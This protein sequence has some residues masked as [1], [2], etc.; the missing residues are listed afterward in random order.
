MPDLFSIYEKQ[1]TKEVTELLPKEVIVQEYKS[2]K[3]RTGKLEDGTEVWVVVD[4]IG[5]VTQSKNPTDYWY[6]IKKRMANEGNELSTNCRVLKIQASNGKFYA[7]E[8]MTREQIFR[9]LQSIPSKKAEPFKL[10]LA[11]LANER[12]E[13]IENPDLAV[14]RGYDGYIKKGKSAKWA[15]ARVESILHRNTLTEKWLD[16]GV[17]EPKDF[18]R[19]TDRESKGTFGK[20]T[21]EMKKEKELTPTQ[22]L[23]DNMTEA[24]I[25]AQNASDMAISLLI[26]KHNPQGYAENAKEVDT[27]S[28]VGATVLAK[29][30]EILKD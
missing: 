7:M 3:L 19:L 8:V 23:R 30:K 27:G 29:L 1:T 11:K 14:Q 20:T 10:W 18:A 25:L 26:D 5:A 2:H 13:E 17:N 6:R 12:L 28:T 15:K 21:G 16:H 9:M 24:E 4:I 22:N